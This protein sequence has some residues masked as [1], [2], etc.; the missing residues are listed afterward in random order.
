ML[1]FLKCTLN[2]KPFFKEIFVSKSINS[3][4]LVDESVSKSKWS[5][6]NTHL[7][8]TS[9]LNNKY[10]NFFNLFIYIFYKNLNYYFLGAE[11]SYKSSVKCSNCCQGIGSGKMIQCSLCHKC[12]HYCCHIPLNS[13]FLLL[14]YLMYTFIYIFYRLYISQFCCAPGVLLLNS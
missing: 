6:L 4:S 7:P 8:S 9:T 10:L 5:V 13:R 1:L 12:Y 11:N 2:L 14:F 3:S